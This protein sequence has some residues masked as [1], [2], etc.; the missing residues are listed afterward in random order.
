[1][2]KQ[3]RRRNTRPEKHLRVRSIRQ[4]PPD[5]ERLTN[6]LLDMALRQAAQEKQAQDERRESNREDR[7]EVPHE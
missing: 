7:H 5:L 2:A 4:D 1:M 3:S 6:A